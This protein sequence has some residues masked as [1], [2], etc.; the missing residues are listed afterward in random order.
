MEKDHGHECSFL[1]GKYWYTYQNLENRLLEISRYIAFDPSNLKT[2]S[3]NLASLLMLVGSNIDTFFK[4]M[5]SCILSMKN[6]DEIQNVVDVI[7]KKKKKDMT[8]SDYYKY[9]SLYQ[10]SKNQVEVPFGLSYLGNISPFKNFK[11]CESPSW[12]TA[13][14]K[15]K[16]EYYENIKMASLENVINA[17]GGLLVLNSLHKCSQKYLWMNKTPNL[18]SNFITFYKGKIENSLVGHYPMSRRPYITTPIFVFK[19]RRDHKY[20]LNKVFG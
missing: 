7:S 2:W 14:N 1:R 10:L 3:E 11:N 9:D 19:L 12:W 18:D 4:D 6:K 16:H 20:D 17:M 5:R 13:Y 8:I 15:I